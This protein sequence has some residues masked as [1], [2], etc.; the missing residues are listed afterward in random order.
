MMDLKTALLQT[1]QSSGFFMPEMIL[2]VL[3]LFLVVLASIRGAS[4]KK[5]MIVSLSS[6]T[7]VL[8]ALNLIDQQVAIGPYRLFSGLVELTTYGVYFKLIVYLSAFLTV[9]MIANSA[10]KF[11]IEPLIFIVSITFG[12]SFLLSSVNLLLTYV[13]LELVSLTSYALVYRSTAKSTEAS[14][15]YLLFGAVSSAIMLY[16]MSLIYG[17]VGSLDYSAVGL[18]VGQGGVEHTNYV[19]LL[20]GLVCLALGLLFK[21]GAFPMHLWIPDVYESASTPIVAFFASAP[22]IGG[23]GA[24]L[25]LFD[26]VNVLFFI[27]IFSL[28]ALLSIFAGNLPALWQKNVKRM[29]AYSSI[30]HSGF[31]LIG[32]QGASIAGLGSGLQVEFHGIYIYAIIYVVMNFSAFLCVQ[33]IEKNTGEVNLDSFAGV[34]R[35]IP[36]L[37]V[38]VVVTMVS[39]IGLPPTGGFMAKLFVFTEYWTIA[40]WMNSWLFWSVLILGLLNA[41]IALFYYIKMPYWAFFKSSLKNTKI[42]VS[43][44]D[45]ILLALTIVVLVGTFIKID[46]LVDLISIFNV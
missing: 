25:L 22:K 31:L 5:V 23:I 8:A 42:I 35:T 36:L 46:W 27:Q 32:L 19:L 10:E 15:K 24:L 28:V 21:V 14:L 39:L 38:C 33:I 29:L 45:K 2:G 26:Q 7:L 4:E 11:T 43:S 12:L 18:V 1:L 3:V 9:L 16:G 40:N 20:I 41:V 34:G 37:G 6:L 44:T 17:T 30:A 13:S